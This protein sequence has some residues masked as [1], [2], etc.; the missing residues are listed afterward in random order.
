MSRLVDNQTYSTYIYINVYGKCMVEK[1]EM[2]IWT[3]KTLFSML[4][5]LVYLSPLSV[6]FSFFFL[7]TARMARTFELSQLAFFHGLG[8][9]SFTLYKLSSWD[10]SIKQYGPV[11]HSE[12]QVC[13]SLAIR[14]NRSFF[15]YFSR[16]THSLCTNWE[17]TGVH[18]D[19]PSKSS[20]FVVILTQNFSKIK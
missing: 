14:W 4:S 12:L 7:S 20:S 18:T 9:V 11:I 19:D 1:T 13:S 10:K 16:T 3:D 17:Q 15:F 6:C 2:S 8:H 5:F